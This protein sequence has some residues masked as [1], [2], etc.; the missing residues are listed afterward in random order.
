MKISTTIVSMI[1]VF[2][3]CAQN[4]E[5]CG[6]DN[7]PVLTAAEGDFL[8]KYMSD[9]QRNG[10]YFTG[11]KAIFVSG[12][13]ASRIGSKLDFFNGIKSWNVDRKKISCGVYILNEQEK[14]DSGGYDIIITYW[15]KVLS[16][17][18]KKKIIKLIKTTP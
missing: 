15:V 18:R 14:S 16:N 8:D 1:L 2:N 5:E 7:N 6:L 11:K 17:S 4:L 12:P 3:L 9:V 13:G 10:L